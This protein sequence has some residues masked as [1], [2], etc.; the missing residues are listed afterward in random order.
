[1][2]LDFYKN[3]IFTLNAFVL[4]LIDERTFFMAVSVR[5]Q[6]FV[7]CLRLP[8]SILVAETLISYSQKFIPTLSCK[9]QIL[10]SYRVQANVTISHVFN[11]FK[12]IN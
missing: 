12:I 1:M 4:H 8:I 9:S 2:L 10:I 5:V 3:L 7:P 6:L 11:S